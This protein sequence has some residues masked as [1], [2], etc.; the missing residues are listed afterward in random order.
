MDTRAKSAA[1]INGKSS[2]PHR[3]EGEN[4]LRMMM[5]IAIKERADMMRPQYNPII[6]WN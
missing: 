5:L 4:F 2:G 6:E 1:L 3:A